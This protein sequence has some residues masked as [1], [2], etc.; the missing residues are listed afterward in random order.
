M[1]LVTNDRKPTPSASG[2]KWNN[3]L[4]RLGILWGGSGFRHTSLLGASL[5]VTGHLSLLLRR[6]WLSHSLSCTGRRGRPAASSFC[7]SKWPS[8]P[9]LAFLWLMWWVFLGSYTLCANPGW[10]DGVSDGQGCELTSEPQKG[11]TL[12]SLT[13]RA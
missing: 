5:A 7:A 3:G 1:M 9:P 13:N 2:E 8:S 10:R 6:P 11:S 4:R 12:Y